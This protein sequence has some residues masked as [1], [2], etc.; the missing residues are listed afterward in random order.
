MERI[1]HKD[2]MQLS[3]L[4]QDI[5]DILTDTNYVDHFR[6]FDIIIHI[7]NLHNH[8]YRRNILIDKSVY[9]NL[10]NLLDDYIKRI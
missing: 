8:L 9:I 10:L 4:Y 7:K 3:L 2:L 1:Y 6:F 5:I